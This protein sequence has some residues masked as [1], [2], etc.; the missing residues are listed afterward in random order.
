M[1]GQLHSQQ[2]KALNTA[3]LEAQDI[4]VLGILLDN[5]LT[6]V[7]F[8]HRMQDERQSGENERP[9]VDLSSF[10]GWLTTQREWKS[11]WT[12]GDLKPGEIASTNYFIIYMQDVFHFPV[13]LQESRALIA[14]VWISRLPQI[15]ERFNSHL[16]TVDLPNV[17]LSV[18]D[19]S[20]FIIRFVH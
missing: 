15:V 20:E 4:I 2:K 10:A 19:E 8:F 1:S 6:N 9:G 18:M 5:A 13:M 14:K 16:L 3:R 11:Y 17:E 7:G 12:L